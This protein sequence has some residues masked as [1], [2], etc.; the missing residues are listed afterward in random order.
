VGAVHRSKVM[1]P[2]AGESPG[3]SC[4][5]GPGLL[6]Y[7][8]EICELLWPSP[9]TVALDRRGPGRFRLF[10]ASRSSAQEAADSEESEFLLIPGH[11]R[12][13]L[14]VPA[15]PRVGTAALRHYGKPA[16]RVARL[17]AKALSFGLA[18]GLGGRVIGT[19]VR[20]HTPP[21]ADT[22]AGYL[23]SVISDDIQVSMHMG[24]PRANRKPVLQLLTP[25]GNTV[26]FAKIG[27]NPLTRDLARTERAS[28]DRLSR[29]GLAGITIPRVL[30]YGEWRGLDVLVLSALPAWRRPRPASEKDL[31]A[32]MSEVACV[33]GLQSEPLADGTYIKR[34]LS[35]LALV[36]EG[37]ERA[38]L[39]NALDALLTR[40]GGAVLTLGAWHGDWTQWNMANTDHGLLVWD[41]ERFMCGVPL[42]FDA[43]H[44]WLQAAVDG[45]R[46]EP[47][48][49][50]T[51]CINRADQLVA[52]FG[53]A[54]QES[55]LTAM[56]YLVD[57]ATRYLTDRQAQAGAPRGA[58]GTWL[59]PAI[60]GETARM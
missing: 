23:R 25:A 59:I 27:V 51:D 13:L 30:H 58:P 38:A 10:A 48:A 26:G 53:V 52:P 20:V 40:A 2:F 4:P 36:D 33:E 12:P 3:Q 60:V 6:A 34:L 37:P 55:R 9:A 46:R 44:Y 5:H 29:A 47:L 19:T 11:R 39:L 16:S 50:A 8:S 56:L 31:A 17:G 14:L 54:A 22:I 28:L 7:L 1:L 43:L 41:W 42:G 32:S 24:A 45:R 18:R 21:G 15:T 57:L 35:R 49:A